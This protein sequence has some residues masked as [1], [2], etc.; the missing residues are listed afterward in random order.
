MSI[1]EV[2]HPNVKSLMKTPEENYRFIMK[3]LRQY[4]NNNAEWLSFRHYVR[5]TASQQICYVHL[6]SKN[7]AVAYYERA[8]YMDYAKSL[9]PLD[10]EKNQELSDM[11]DNI[12]GRILAISGSEHFGSIYLPI[13]K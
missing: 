1:L 13:P 6:G 8:E 4:A 11:L 9:Y 7:L 2:K 5:N 3:Y 10:I 12:K